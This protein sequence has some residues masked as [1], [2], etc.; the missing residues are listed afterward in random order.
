MS[1]SS[2]VSHPSIVDVLQFAKPAE[3]LSVHVP[4]LHA[5]VE[6]GPDVQQFPQLPQITQTAVHVPPLHVVPGHALPHAP[7]FERSSRVSTQRSLQHTSFAAHDAH[8]V[9]ASS[10]SGASVSLFA[11]S[12]PAS[13]ASAGASMLSAT[14]ARSL[15]SSNP[16]Y[17]PRSYAWQAA[18]AL[19]SSTSNAS[20]REVMHS[21]PTRKSA[22]VAATSRGGDQNATAP[23]GSGGGFSTCDGP[24]CMP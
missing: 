1:V 13:N 2:G 20:E 18:S 3:R 19:T 7:Q 22:I 21:N 11:P 5:A 10:P 16:L 24:P 9:I 15:A 4:M 23:V 6:F 14:S 12:R 17:R 8:A